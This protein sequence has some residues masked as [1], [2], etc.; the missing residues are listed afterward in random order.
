[1]LTLIAALDTNNLIGNKN[2]LPWPHFPADMSHFKKTTMGHPIVMGR[3]TFES[4]GF[5][6]PGRK[7]IVLTRSPDLDIPGA[8]TYSNL[9]EVL[10]NL[11]QVDAFIIGG[12]QIYELFLPHAERIILTRIHAS[13]E[14][15]TYFPDIDAE[16]WRLTK[17][18]PLGTD[19]KF[20]LWI[21]EYARVSSKQENGLPALHLSE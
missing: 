17:E 2:Q 11:S 12:R 16:K 4:I 8:D 1:M 21:E 15:D 18:E 10:R 9:E 19:K 6:L 13:F 20:K 14:G 7:N 5:I 3:K